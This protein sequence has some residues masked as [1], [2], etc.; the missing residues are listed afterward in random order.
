MKNEKSVTDPGAG[1]GAGAGA[2]VGAGAGAG[3]GAG[4]VRQ[5]HSPFHSSASTQG[6]PR[7]RPTFSASGESSRFH[8]N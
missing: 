4:N 6:S 3:A 1:A 2:G 5:R 8:Q 7:A